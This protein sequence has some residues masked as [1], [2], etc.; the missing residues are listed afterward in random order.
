VA[1][2]ETYI[3]QINKGDAV[4]VTFDSLPGK[5]F[6]AKVTEV[7]VGATGAATT[8]PVTARMDNPDPTI[9]SGLAANMT[10]S[11]GGAND[12]SSIVVPMQAVGEDRD[13]RFVFI[14]ERKDPKLGIVRRRPVTVG[15]LASTECRL[16]GNLGTQTCEG[17]EVL[18]GLKDGELVVTAGVKRLIDGEEVK[19][20]N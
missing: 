3:A 12:K 6:S 15:R 1:I 11:F 18:E 17:I 4:T 19:L 10:F 2:P 20:L 14:L 8:F 7:G 16:L 5:E 13:G 9:R